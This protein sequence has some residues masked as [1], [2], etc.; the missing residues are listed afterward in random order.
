MIPTVIKMPTVDIT[1]PLNE[2]RRFLN[3]MEEEAEEME[4]ALECL[5]KHD[6]DDTDAYWELEAMKCD[7][8]A[9]IEEISEQLE[10]QTPNRGLAELFE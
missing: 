2:A 3:E 8:E 10:E 7:K 6:L 1:V 5:Q 9:G 4:Y